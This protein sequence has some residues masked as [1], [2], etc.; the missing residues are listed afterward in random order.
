MEASNQSN[1]LPWPYVQLEQSKKIDLTGVFMV[2]LFDMIILG[3]FAMNW[4]WQRRQKA[5]G[6]Q[7]N[8]GSDSSSATLTV[9]D[10]GKSENNISSVPE[11]P[12]GDDLGLLVE[13]FRKCNPDGEGLGLAFDYHDL[14]LTVDHGS[15]T[16]L[17]KVNG[18]IKAGTMWGVMGPSG[19][20][21]SGSP[22]LYT[23]G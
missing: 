16:L 6:I 1:V 14:G 4:M 7:Y 21:K 22:I 8:Q 5:K 19:A 2:I 11:P 10:N 3:I 9:V 13:S 23:H 15:K 12:I 20:G 17:S 18:S